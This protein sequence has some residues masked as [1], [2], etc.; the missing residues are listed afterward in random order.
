MEGV[1]NNGLPREIFGNKETG[2]ELMQQYKIGNL[3]NRRKEVYTRDTS[4]RT[5]VISMRDWIVKKG[6]VR[7]Y[8]ELS[9]LGNQGNHQLRIYRRSWLGIWE[10]ES[11]EKN[12]FG[13]GWT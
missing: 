1:R 7:S 2:W 4:G 8:S 6:K 12:G 10:Y 9:A 13:F 11:Q 3:K 5:Q